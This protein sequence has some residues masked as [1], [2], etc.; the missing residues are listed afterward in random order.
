MRAPGHRRSSDE[1][2]GVMGRNP[3]LL[4]LGVALLTS[5]AHRRS[6]VIGRRSTRPAAVC[7]P[8]SV[9]TDCVSVRVQHSRARA[10]TTADV[11]KV[12]S[13]DS[14][15]IQGPPPDTFSFAGLETATLT[16][17]ELSTPSSPACPLVSQPEWLRSSYPDHH[18]LPPADR[19]LAGQPL[20]LLPL[21][22]RRG[23]VRDWLG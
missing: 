1:T 20:S 3:L 17:S 10:R 4:R 14:R 9:W 7:C 21:L 23:F 6:H 2:T 22:L 12:L 8:L 18:T 5:G 15:S 11:T 16:C 13:L 19:T